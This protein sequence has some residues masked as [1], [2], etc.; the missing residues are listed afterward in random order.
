MPASGRTLS[1]VHPQQVLP[2]QE[3]DF[4]PPM[5][6]GGYPAIPERRARLFVRFQK[7]PSRTSSSAFDFEAP[8]PRGITASS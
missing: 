1:I 4:D 5:S 6:R 3:P 2:N 7:G 8:G